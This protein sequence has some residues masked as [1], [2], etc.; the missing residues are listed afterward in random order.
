MD[1]S[2]L[3]RASQ[4]M[5]MKDGLQAYIRPSGELIGQFGPWWNVRSFALSGY[6][7]S[8]ACSPSRVW[9]SW[10]DPSRHQPVLPC[11]V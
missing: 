1:P 9:K 6:R 7:P 10:S 5:T 3:P 2:L 4:L 11:A 8:M